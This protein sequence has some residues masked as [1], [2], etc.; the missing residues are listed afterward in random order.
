MLK[1][2][3]LFYCKTESYAQ[4]SLC[5]STIACC[6][7]RAKPE[8]PMKTTEFVKLLKYKREKFNP[9][10]K[11]EATKVC[12]AFLREVI[13][14]L[15]LEG[16]PG[17]SHSGEQWKGCITPRLEVQRQRWQRSLDIWIPTFKESW[18]RISEEVLFLFLSHL[19]SHSFFFF[20]FFCLGTPV[21]EVNPAWGSGKESF[22][23]DMKVRKKNSLGQ[24]KNWA[25][26]NPQCIN[27]YYNYEI[28][29]YWKFGR[30]S[31]PSK[32]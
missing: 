29:Q 13:P 21:T 25:Q 6:F 11:R 16:Q 32:A 12:N 26:K 10:R 15:P 5:T 23:N 3:Q 28:Q 27:K 17:V 4:T 14:E 20:F 24:R 18:E 7:Q 22:P 2:T 30:L 1:A 19:S 8:F 9:V 31:R